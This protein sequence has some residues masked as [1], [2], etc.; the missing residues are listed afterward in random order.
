MDVQSG[1]VHVQQSELDEPSGSPS[2]EGAL[3]ALHGIPSACA[4]QY[5]SAT[6]AVIPL[7]DRVKSRPHSRNS[8]EQGMNCMRNLGLSPMPKLH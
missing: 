4:G 2:Q 8:A 5:L 3:A 6:S 7:T 1:I